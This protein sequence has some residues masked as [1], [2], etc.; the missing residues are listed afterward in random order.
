[1]TQAVLLEINRA[2]TGFSSCASEDGDE[3]VLNRN[4]SRSIEK[5]GL[6]HPSK[7]DEYGASEDPVA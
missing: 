7:S 5:N 1:V 2:G 6:A 4:L 3:A